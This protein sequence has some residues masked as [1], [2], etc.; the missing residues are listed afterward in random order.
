MDHSTMS[1][2][3]VEW[4]RTV[5]ASSQESSLIM[6]IIY[7]AYAALEVKLKPGTGLDDLQ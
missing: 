1:V 3:S 7:G 6:I 5:L 2:V 4:W